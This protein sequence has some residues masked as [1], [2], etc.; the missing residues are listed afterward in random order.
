MKKNFKLGV[1]GGGFMAQSIIE[2]VLNGFS[3]RIKPKNI[4]VS[5]LSD[6]IL[7]KFSNK[8]INTTKSNIDIVNF[9]DFVLFAVKP[10]SLNA[11]AEELKENRPKKIITIM[12]GVTKKSLKNTFGIDT[13][14][15][16]CM[17][18]TP[19]SI[20]SGVVA[21]DLSDFDNEDKEFITSIFDS[22]AEIILLDESKMN[23]VTG[24]SGS[25]PA[26]VYLFIDSL[27]EAGKKQGLSEE[28]AKVL[29]IN[30]V[31]GGA[32]MLIENPNKDIKDLI[33]AVCSKGGT[34][35]E[36]MKK[37]EENNFYDII[38]QSVEACVNRAEELSKQC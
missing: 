18:N 12:A 4:M 24:I 13:K 30:T 35:I 9:A 5:D 20:G 31:Y 3:N 7:V 22:I 23:A 10:Q 29:A 11:V 27:I 19:C 2:G 34:T 36:A 28:E 32:E 1:I 8:K 38:N 26:Y 14:V 15:A 16:R 37:F 6:E 25:G 17:P 33:K 21:I